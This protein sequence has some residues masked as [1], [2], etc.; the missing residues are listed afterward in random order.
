[1]K[2]YTIVFALPLLTLAACG[3]NKKKE[4]E[5]KLE[6]FDQKISYMI[7]NNMGNN[8]RNERVVTVDIEAVI[9][10]L[11]DAFA[12]NAQLKI[13]EG[14][15]DSLSKQY[16][17]AYYKRQDEELVASAA[18]NE[19]AGQQFM[20]EYRKKEGVGMT[21]TGVLYEI[22]SEGKGPKP[23]ADDSVKVHYKGT[24][25]DGSVFDS[26]IDRGEPVT[27]TLR[28]VIPGW[29]EGLQLMNEGTK[30]KLVIPPNMAYGNRKMGSIPPGSTLVFEIELLKVYKVKK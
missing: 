7:G 11:R 3:G 15:I 21:E 24:L 27:F 26:S 17:M 18:P 8:L 13:S 5:A 16:E 2:V 29:T 4:K 14:E 28:G 9:Q 23:T 30:F 20:S 19:A 25:V 6:S 12:E 1:M 10:G 22:L